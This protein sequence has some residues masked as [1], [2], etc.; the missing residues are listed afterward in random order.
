MVRVEMPSFLIVA[1]EK[2]L[3]NWVPVPAD[4]LTTRDALAWFA[5]LPL[6]VLRVPAC[7]ELM[8]VPAFSTATNTVI[9]Q[10]PF[11]GILPPVRVMSALPLAAV[12]VP[13]QVLSGTVLGRP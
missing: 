3:S 10:V 9:L 8:Y 1:G 6:L 11:A 7:S 4:A 12:S 2:D 13:P 5:L